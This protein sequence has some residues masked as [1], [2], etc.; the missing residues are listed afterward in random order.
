MGGKQLGQVTGKEAVMFGFGKGKPVDVDSWQWNDDS[1]NDLEH[2]GSVQVVQAQMMIWT[3]G[4]ASERTRAEALELLGAGIESLERA[5]SIEDPP[6]PLPHVC[7]AEGYAYK[8]WC[9]SFGRKER[10]READALCARALK[11]SQRA[12]ECYGSCIGW[13][14]GS[15][16][17]F[18]LA[19]ALVHFQVEDFKQALKQLAVAR[20]YRRDSSLYAEQADK[21]E[22]VL[23]KH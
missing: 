9:L 1:A 15:R 3:Q 21:L 5:I 20:S 23:S 16:H 17:D 6:I 7:L 19:I 8:A 11:E 4:I 13:D 18:H 12:L 22:R 2:R 14:E 10:S